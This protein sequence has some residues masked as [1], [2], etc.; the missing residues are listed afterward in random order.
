MGR[1]RKWLDIDAEQIVVDFVRLGAN[2][3][4]VD[5]LKRRY[6]KCPFLQRQLLRER[7][8][9]VVALV[10]ETRARNDQLGLYKRS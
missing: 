3:A 10:F 6:D 9:R 2:Q 4:A 5:E 8:E 1:H 7:L